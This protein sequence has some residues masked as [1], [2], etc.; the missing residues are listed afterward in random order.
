M[1]ERELVKQISDEINKKNLSVTSYVNTAGKLVL[2]TKVSDKKL[3]DTASI[4][5]GT[6]TV[7]TGVYSDITKKQII[8]LVGNRGDTFFQRW[9]S[10]KTMPRSSSDYNQIV[11]IASVMIESHLNL[12]GRTDVNRG[13]TKM[14]NIDYNNFGKINEVYTQVNVTDSAVAYDEDVNTDKYP[15]TVTWTME[16]KAN[17]DIDEWT[18]ITL[19]SSIS[20]DGNL[21]AVTALRRFQNSLIAFQ[22]KGISEILFNSRTQISTEDGTPIEIANSNKVDGKRYITSQY[23]V[24]NKKAIIEGRGGLYFVDHANCAFC[25]CNGQS[26]RN[27]STEKQFS[28]W[29]NQFKWYSGPYIFY[30]KSFYDSRNSDVYIMNTHST[31]SPCLVF[32]EILDTFT[33]FYDYSKIDLMINIDNKFISFRDKKFW[34]Q[35]EGLFCNFFGVQYPFWVTYRATPSPFTDK[36]WTNIEYR[37]DAHSILDVNG[38]NLISASALN[39]QNDD[40]LIPSNNYNKSN[41]FNYIRVWDEYQ[42]TPEFSTT[43]VKKFRTWRLAIPR[44]VKSETNKFGLDRIRNP[45]VFVQLKK[46]YKLLEKDNTDL[47]ELHDAILKYFE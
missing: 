7:I 24:S 32:N 25:S 20:L 43:A 29:F 11:D 37:A 18:H 26:V 45:W 30:T 40:V 10:V 8:Q 13:T 9:D 22:E 1:T 6:E 47:I 44:A 42:E 16:K 15:T 39:N 34:F 3:Y 19:G 46:D 21:G 4:Q 2:S 5:C 35:N 17:A 23:G 38:D 31:D 14:T 27:I 41:T 36:I 28:S 12:D 33:S